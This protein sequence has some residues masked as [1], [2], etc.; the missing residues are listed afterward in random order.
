MRLSVLGLAVFSA[1]AFGQPWVPDDHGTLKFD[2]LFPRRS[3]FGAS[4]RGASWSHDDRFVAYLWNPYGTRGSDLWLLDTKT[5]KSRALTSI[6][7]MGEFDP[8][9][10]R[11]KGRYAKEDSELDEREKLS[12]QDYRKDQVKRRKER[13]GRNRPEPSYP[14]ISD[15]HWSSEGHRMLLVYRGD[16]YLWAEGNDKLQRLTRT[17]DQESDPRWVKGDKQ[18]TF[19]RG[20]GIY[21]M[22]LDSST[23]EQLD[24]QL[25][26]NMPIFGYSLSPDGTR[27]MLLTGRSTGEYRQ[28]EWISYRGRFAQVQRSSQF[29]GTPDEKIQEERFLYLFDLTKDD[30]ETNKPWEVWSWKSSGDE[31]K[32]VSTSETPWS[33][34]GKSFVFAAYSNLSREVEINVADLAAKNVKSVYKSKFLGEDDGAS[35]SEPRFTPDG[36]SILCLMETTGYRLPWLID[37]VTGSGKALVQGEFNAQPVQLSEDG[38]TLVVRSTAL[39]PAR[40]QL[41]KVDMASGSFQRW[42]SQEGNYDNPVPSHSCRTALVHFANWSSPTETYLVGDG[43]KRITDSH[44]PGAFAKVNQIKPTLV[45]FKN[46]HGQSVYGYVFL[47]PGY[48]KSQ[49]RPCMVYTYGGPLGEGNSVSDGSFNSTG[50]LFNM[51]LAQ[52]YGFVTATFDPRGSSGYGAA[53]V[54]ASFGAVGEPQTEDLVDAAKWLQAEYNVDPKKM[55]LNGWSF[56]GWQTQHVLYHQPGVYTLGIAGA[57]PTEWQNY[58]QGYVQETIGIQPEGKIEDLDKFSLTKVAMNLKDP[59]MLLHGMEDSNVLF[60]HTIAVYRVLCQ[61]GLAPLVE[62]VVDPTGNHGLGGDIDRRDTLAL[63]LRFIQTH[64]GERPYVAGGQP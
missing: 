51:Y 42:T 35:A 39:H 41:Y 10:V 29:W 17:R 49:Q 38:K 18:F 62:L 27:M 21:R 11:A 45:S 58:N 43:E 12:L 37:P 64:W 24:P 25:P 2:D 46:R 34:D 56:G 19:R 1:C 60:Q 57:G 16:L 5:G 44:R 54:R 4:A 14:G 26:N 33:P 7:V 47:P 9:A 52:E 20:T 28:I 31:I 6:D 36:A 40:Q 32:G 23:I 30:P 55:A 15:F 22:S 61:Y 48:D 59:L 63:Y 50:Y 13:E 8:D 53:F 3:F